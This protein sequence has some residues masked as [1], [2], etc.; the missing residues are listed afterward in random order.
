MRSY[1]KPSQNLSLRGSVDLWMPC[2]RRLAHHP[3]DSLAHGPCHCCS[4]D[5]RIQHV[6]GH[7]ADLYSAHRPAHRH[8]DYMSPSN[9]DASIAVHR[10][11]RRDFGEPCTNKCQFAH[12]VS[13]PLVKCQFWAHTP[14]RDP[15][16]AEQCE[17]Q[18]SPLTLLL[19]I[20]KPVRTEQCAEH[21][22]VMC[23]PSDNCMPDICRIQ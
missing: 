18:L 6:D 2:W 21:I 12:A 15:V 23:S 10:L 9:R 8:L 20:R 22:T 3:D 7:A 16:A 19:N 17:Y 5:D 4:E 11:H 13:S 14:C 1:A